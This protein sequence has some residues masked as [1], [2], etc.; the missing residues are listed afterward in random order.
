MYSRRNAQ[1]DL[2]VIMQVVMDSVVVASEVHCTTAMFDAQ[3]QLA[4]TQSLAFSVNPN[5][6]GNVRTGA[7]MRI[8]LRP[9]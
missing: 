1:Y 8:L 4:D 9:C 7:V 6:P 2:G 3:G 5:P